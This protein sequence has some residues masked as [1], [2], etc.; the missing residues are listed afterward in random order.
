MVQLNFTVGD[1]KGN[2][3]KIINSIKAAKSKG[4]DIVTFPEL[5]ITGYPPEG[6]LL[7]KQFIDDNLYYLNK[8]KDATEDIV[9]VVG[10]ANRLKDNIYN[11]AAVIHKKKV[12]G[13]YNKMLLPNYGVFDEKRY[14]A[15]GETSLLFNLNGIIFGIGICEDIWHDEVTLKPL[16]SGGAGLIL[17]INASPYYEGKINL[18]ESVVK[19]VAKKYKTA[20]SYNNLVGGQDELIF[21]GQSLFVDEKG[22]IL[23]KGDAFNEEMVIL[24]VELKKY[25]KKVSHKVINIPHY[26]NPKKETISKKAPHKLSELEEVYKALTMGLRDYVMKNN[27]KKVVLGLSG[28]IDS[29]L[30]A[31]IAVDAL[32]KENVFGVFMPSEFTSEESFI[33]A[34]LLARNLGIDFH[35]IPINALFDGYLGS[36]DKIFGNM[37][38]NIAE[39]NLQAR[40]RGNLLMALSNKFGYLVLTTGNK[41]EISC[42]YC[43]LYGDTVGGFSVL[44]DVPKT[45]VYKLS[46]YR[47]SVSKVIPGNVFTKAPTAEL[48]PNQ[49]DTDSLPPYDTLD[50][51]LKSYIEDNK[52]PQEI[53]KEGFDGKIVNKVI[54]MV[55][56]NEYKRRQAAPGVKITPKALGRDRRM[57][58]TNRY[59]VR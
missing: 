46:E 12:L 45:L 43:T 36:L 47:N 8:I 27:F 31:A 17:I 53:I 30:T 15:P 41:S 49:K 23:L 40:I 42:G 19:K 9:A 11:S 18:R 57:P 7:K 6:L 10:F 5:S 39:E 50:K 3:E 21:D 54:S 22:K 48:R 33:D 58:V 20:I 55:D 59:K 51:I 35:E 56:N 13:I 16:A 26:I 25:L 32:G 4:V 28:G 34:K 14:F 29:A 38:K 24:D 37:P 1:L 52:S 2:S 44:K